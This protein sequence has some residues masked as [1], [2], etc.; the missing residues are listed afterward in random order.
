MVNF[1]LLRHLWLFQ[2]VAEERHF[3]RAA[4]RVGMSQPPLTE[5]IKALE[6]ALGTTLFVRDRCGVRLTAAG[7]A[8]LP[9][10]VKLV[11][12]AGRLELGRRW[13]AGPAH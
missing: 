7:A 8:I 2:A 1:R 9:A 4:Q 11:D 3:G 13:Q 12:Q 5:Q 6:Q 10:V